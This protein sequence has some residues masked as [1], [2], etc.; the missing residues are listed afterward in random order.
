LDVQKEYFH[1][2]DDAI[3][4]IKT[5]F[6]RK[7]SQETKAVK[8]MMSDIDEQIKACTLCRL[9]LQRK[10]A[11]PGEGDPHADILFIGEGPGAQEDILGRPFVGAAGQLLTKM[12]AAIQLRR[13]EVYITNIVK[14]RPPENR[15]PLPDEIEAC[16]YYLEQQIELINPLVIVCLGGP[17]IQTLTRSSNGISRLRGTFQQYKNFPVIPT[18]HPAAVLRFPEK[19]K[20]AVWNDLKM[21]RDYYRDV[22]KKSSIGK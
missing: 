7:G 13:E 2:I 21:L 1:L 9:H 16:F 19:Y 14:C 15:N 8:I 17:A 11:V 5:G 6:R 3:S 12:L 22:K 20:K 10:N 18:Y 4:Y